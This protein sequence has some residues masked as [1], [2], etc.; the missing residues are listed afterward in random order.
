M[1]RHCQPLSRTCCRVS[2]SAYNTSS[3]TYPHTCKPS[4]T[5]TSYRCYVHL[6]PLHAMRQ[7]SYTYIGCYPMLLYRRSETR[8]CDYCHLHAVFCI[9][10]DW[11]LCGYVFVL[12]AAV[13]LRARLSLSLSLSLSVDYS[14]CIFKLIEYEQKINKRVV[15]FSVTN[16]VD[17]NKTSE[18][19]FAVYVDCFWCPITY[20]A[21]ALIARL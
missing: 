15:S 4:L 2:A 14:I 6:R 11:Q 16:Q 21:R 8:N 18:K 10:N 9:C 5:V 7:N 1:T 12:L 19:V 3:H 17:E 20:Y 13:E